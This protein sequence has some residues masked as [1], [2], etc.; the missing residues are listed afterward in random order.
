LPSNETFVSHTE[1]ALK[2]KQLDISDIHGSIQLEPLSVNALVLKAAPVS[3][4]EVIF[5]QT[6]LKVFP[7]PGSGMINIEFNLAKPGPVHMEL[8]NGNGQK[9]TSLS[10][11]RSSAGVHHFQAD[12]SEY[13]AG[14]YWIT[15]RSDHFT[16]TRKFILNR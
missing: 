4:F 14:F 9:M 12:L 5:D 1:N 16:E 2:I 3:A 7:N 6:G 10:H 11:A 8:Y 13:P 15:I